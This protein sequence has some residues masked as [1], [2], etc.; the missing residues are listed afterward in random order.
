MS[1]LLHAIAPPAY[2]L[3]AGL[4]LRDALRHRREAKPCLCHFLKAAAYAL[5][6]LAAL[7]K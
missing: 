1:D 6:G 3:V 5:L 4:D 2:L 7:V